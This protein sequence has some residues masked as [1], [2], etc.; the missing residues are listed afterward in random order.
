MHELLYS[1]R[2][3]R[4]YTDQPVDRPTLL[5][6]LDAATRAP[7]AHN[8]QPWRFLAI[9][10][11]KA[12]REIADA[13]GERLRADR[14]ADGDNEAVVEQDLHRSKLRVGNAPAL[15]FVFFNVRE[16]DAYPDQRR[17]DAEY[18]MAVQST[19]MAMQNLLLAAHAE[20]LGACLMCAPLFCPDT[21]TAKLGVAPDWV[22]QS[23]VVLGWPAARP[24]HRS[25]LALSEVATIRE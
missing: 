25:R 12:K 10:D 20:G 21:V 17:R 13:M 5:R 2:S 24:P 8:R 22:P 19:A 9:T 6:L 23:L 18:T 15:V 3:V 14:L 4:R 7:S 16:L 1:R 11:S